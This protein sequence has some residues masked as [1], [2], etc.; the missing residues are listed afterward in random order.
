M[1]ALHQK[2]NGCSASKWIGHPSKGTK[3][4]HCRKIMKQDKPDKLN[5]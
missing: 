2:K 5:T 1:Q 3:M 4:A